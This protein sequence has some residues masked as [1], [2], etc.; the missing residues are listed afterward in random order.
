[1]LEQIAQDKRLT[2]AQI[3]E[4]RRF[5]LEAAEKPFLEEQAR[6]AR[7][8][9]ISQEKSLAQ[10]QIAEEKRLAQVQIEEK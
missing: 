4:N 8:A 9:R 6:I 7:E 1:M 3:A 5:E 10:A 2:Y